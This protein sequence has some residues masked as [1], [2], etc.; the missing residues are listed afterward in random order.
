MNDLKNIQNNL[1]EFGFNS[2]EI[3]VY[4]ALLGLGETTVGPI[5]KKTDLHRQVVYN[6]LDDLIDKKF[7]SVQIK[8]NRQNYRLT[9]PK[10][11]VTEAENQ[12]KNAQE[13]F[14]EIKKTQT[15]L[16]F[17][18]EIKIYEGISGLQELHMEMIYK[19]ER[20]STI[21]IIGAGGLDWYNRMKENNV[22]KK[23][24]KIRWQ[25]K[26][27]INL[28][29]FESRRPEV[30]QMQ[31]MDL[32]QTE[33]KNKFFRFLPENFANPVVTQIWHIQF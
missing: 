30:K 3:K 15:S 18:H 10:N 4:L 31:D 19:M 26:I 12:V 20:N 11:F 21:N 16:K 6:T 5:V 2:N 8:K 23:F 14:E 32:T 28:I 13:L 24:E 1:T 17:E 29:T 25:K 9:N 27:K 22:L 7:V 33:I